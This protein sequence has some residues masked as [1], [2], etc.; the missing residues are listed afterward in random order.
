MPRPR[1]RRHAWLTWACTRPR[2]SATTDIFPTLFPPP[3]ALFKIS[4]GPPFGRARRH[5]RTDSGGGAP[6]A[7]VKNPLVEHHLA[8]GHDWGP[9]GGGLGPAP[10]PPRPMAERRARRPGRR[11]IARARRPAR[12]K[13]RGLFGASVL[14][15][16]GRGAGVGIA[17]ARR[18][19]RAGVGKSPATGLRGGGWWGVAGGRQN[20]AGGLTARRLDCGPQ[21]RLRRSAMGGAGSKRPP[22]CV[23]TRGP[24]HTFV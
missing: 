5:G 4:P 7:E 10:G 14:R 12:S 15:G 19:G 11:A 6:Y 22:R 18:P 13:A 8:A 17:R 23:T 24:G 21:K 20:L 3:Y 9:R 1:T 16:G 2:C